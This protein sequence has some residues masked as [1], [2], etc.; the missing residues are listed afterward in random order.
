MLFCMFGTHFCGLTY[1]NVLDAVCFTYIQYNVMATLC[2]TSYKLFLLR[3][4][5]AVLSKKAKGEVSFL[6]YFQNVEM[7]CFREC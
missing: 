2:C 6:L 4:R 5:P 7:D 3:W 1:S